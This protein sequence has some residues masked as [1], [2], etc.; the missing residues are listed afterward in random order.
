MV[1]KFANQIINLQIDK[2]DFFKDKII[3][4]PLKWL[5][6]MERWRPSDRL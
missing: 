6:G 2:E 4:D 3:V 1:K 5:I